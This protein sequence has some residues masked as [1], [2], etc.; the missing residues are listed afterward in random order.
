MII[1]NNVLYIEYY[2][3]STYSIVIINIKHSSLNLK[4]EKK[5]RTLE[6]AF[7]PKPLILSM[8]ACMD[9]ADAV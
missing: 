9:I 3:G 6:S 2:V 4:F 7:T 5:S 1:D 8:L